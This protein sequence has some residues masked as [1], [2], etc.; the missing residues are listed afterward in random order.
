[1][2][3]RVPG[4]LGRS[5]LDSALLV[6]VTGPAHVNGAKSMPKRHSGHSAWSY[7]INSPPLSSVKLLG[8]EVAVRTG[9][10]PELFTTVRFPWGLG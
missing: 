9:S 10:G 7:I 5:A 6:A 3:F 8:T 2:R 1:M 4:V